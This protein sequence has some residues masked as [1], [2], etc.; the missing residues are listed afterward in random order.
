[1]T[2]S[3]EVVLA[4]FL[5]YVGLDRKKVVSGDIHNRI[6]AQK[7]VYFGKELGLPL[8]YDFNLY[9]YGPYSSALADDYFRMSEEE[10][11]RGQIEIPANISSLINKL[12]KY[13][14]LFLEIAATLHSLKTSNPEASEKAIINGVL[15]LKADRLRERHME[16][17]YI[18]EIFKIL[19]EMNL[20]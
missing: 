18:Q 2:D 3:K 11:A 12:S 1:M 14:F 5:K 6:K 7:L 10:W 19:R 4:G 15:S 16:L 9:L 17:D 8:D 13:D 20:I